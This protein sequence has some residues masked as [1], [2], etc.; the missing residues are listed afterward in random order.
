[1][2]VQIASII[3]INNLLLILNEMKSKRFE[4]SV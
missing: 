4:Y 3:N 1:M 2:D